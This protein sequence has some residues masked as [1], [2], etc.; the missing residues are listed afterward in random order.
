[1]AGDITSTIKSV[2][3][4]PFRIDVV[5]FDKNNFGMWRCEVLDVHQISKTLYGW[6][7]NARLLLKRIGTR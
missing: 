2:N 1:M 7:K 4:H 5:K 6:R 3:P